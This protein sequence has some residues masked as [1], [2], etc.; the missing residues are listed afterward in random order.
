[1]SRR[2][3]TVALCALAAAGSTDLRSSGATNVS[4]Q[5][6]VWTPAAITTAGYES[7]PTFTPDGKEMYFVSADQQFRNYRILRSRCEDGT[8]SA[9][10]AA[11]FGLPLPIIEADPHVTRD[12]RRL[13]FISSRHAPSHEDF[14][15]WYVERGEGGEWGKPQRLPEP[16]N[17]PSAELL[18]RTSS[19]G[20][21]Y[22]GSDRPGGYGQ[23]DIYAGAPQ[24]DG[25]WRVVNVAPPVS[26]A[27][28]DYEA[29]ISGD[30]RTLILVSD[31]GDKSHLYRFVKRGGEWS[32]IG[33]LQA[34]AGVFQV[35]PTLSP[36]GDRLLFAQALEG[37]SGEMFLLDLNDRPI[38]SW[39]PCSEGKGPQPA[40]DNSSK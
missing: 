11:P 29:E 7:S 13:Y 17:S 30:G 31:R 8:W 23:S 2:L 18:P 24:S 20:T 12:G 19:D 15:I 36:A 37:R 27:A 33:R 10:D 9:P 34:A 28:N 38:S 3:A 25:S 16:I 35:G 6:V 1:M 14:D 21:L 40:I 32:E 22:F 39:P 26:S 4:R 5:P